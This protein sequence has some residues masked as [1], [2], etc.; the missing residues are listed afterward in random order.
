MN[1][2]RHFIRDTTSKNNGNNWDAEFKWL[3]YQDKKKKKKTLPPQRQIINE[4]YVE[5]EE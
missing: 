2:L 5:D 1:N 3:I 4:E